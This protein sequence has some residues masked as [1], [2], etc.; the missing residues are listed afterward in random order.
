MADVRIKT[1]KDGPYEIIGAVEQID[2]IVVSAVLAEP[3]RLAARAPGRVD[4]LAESRLLGAG[5]RV[6]LARHGVR[7]RRI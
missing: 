3:L 2:G 7:E 1:L 6:D 4:Q 5:D